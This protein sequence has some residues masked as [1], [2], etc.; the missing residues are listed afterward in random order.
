MREKGLKFKTYLAP[1][2]VNSESA[3]SIWH[4]ISVYYYK[5]PWTCVVTAYTYG[6]QVRSVEGW[7]QI[8]NLQKA[9]RL[10]TPPFCWATGTQ[11]PFYVLLNQNFK[12]SM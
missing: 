12:L 5:W 7:K 11:C 2:V 9:K 10:V 3:V 6:S 4:C 8:A 1:G